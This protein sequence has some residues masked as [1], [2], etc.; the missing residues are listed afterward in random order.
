LEQSTTCEQNSSA[1]AVLVTA[2]HTKRSKPYL[3][4]TI[5]CSEAKYCPRRRRRSQQEND[6]AKEGPAASI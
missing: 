3:Q 2:P 1:T 5:I 4:S 6:E